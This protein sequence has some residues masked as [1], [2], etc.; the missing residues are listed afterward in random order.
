MKLQSDDHNDMWPET[1][2]PTPLE[3]DDELIEKLAAIEHQR[4]ADWQQWVHDQCEIP[5]GEDQPD[6]L[7]IPAALAMRWQ[8]QIKTPY[9]DLSEAEKQSDRDQVMRYWPLLQ[10]YVSTKERE[11]VYGFHEYIMGK[12]IIRPEQD[13]AFNY[14]RLHKAIDQYIAK[15]NAKEKDV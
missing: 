5:E 13:Q 9:A 1:P 2:K 11:A 10:A 7:V 14:G 15:L 6:G 4:W 3:G 12:D 8:R